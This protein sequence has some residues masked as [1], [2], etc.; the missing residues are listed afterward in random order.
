MAS[1][2]SDN[3]PD[4]GSSELGTKDWD[5]AYEKEVDNFEDIGDVG[6][7]WFGEETMDKIISWIEKC[8]EVKANDPI[9]DLGSGNG[10]MCIELSKRGFSQ[11]VGVD[12][13]ELAVMLSRSVAKAEGCEE[14][15]FETGDLITS[16]RPNQCTCLTRKY[17]VVLDKGTYDAI[18]LSPHDSQSAQLGYLA[19]VKDLMDS[20]SL[21][22]I[23]SCNWTKDQLTDFFKDFKLHDEIKFKT[24]QFGGKTGSTYTSLVL[25]LST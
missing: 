1:N 2:D 21:F 13:S 15:V 19:T 4:F 10:M 25:K 16:E 9:I 23:T 6:E 22:S 7:V 8:P 5:S 3:L 14:V 12:Y 20:D 11:L 17:K 24:I 18:S